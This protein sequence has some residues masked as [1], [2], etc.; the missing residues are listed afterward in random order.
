MGRCAGRAGGVVLVLQPG[1]IGLPTGAILALASALFYALSLISSRQ[2]SRPENSHNILFY[3]AAV[4]ILVSG[5]AGALGEL[6]IAP[7]LDWSPLQR[8]DLW[9][10]VVVGCAGSAGQFFFNQAFRYGEV[11]MLAPIEYTAMLWAVV[12]GLVIWGDL[13][14]WM[15]VAGAAVIAGSSLYIS[16]REALAARVAQDAHRP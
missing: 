7:A 1:G 3:Y 4:V 16:R 8:E 14:T 5:T 11:S 10:F 6:G 12:Y 9:I 15:V 13:P 2:M